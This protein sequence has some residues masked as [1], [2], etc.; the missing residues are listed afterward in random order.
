MRYCGVPLYLGK[1]NKE[2]NNQFGYAWVPISRRGDLSNT[3]V[4]KIQCAQPQNHWHPPPTAQ[5]L[6]PNWLIFW[7]EAP[8]LIA[9]RGTEA[10]FESPSGSRDM[11]PF[12]A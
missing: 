1:Q 6:G 7:Q 9:F 10:I 4:I 8:H 2:F 5:T 12:L 3:D 11:S